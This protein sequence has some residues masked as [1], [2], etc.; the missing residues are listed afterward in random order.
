MGNYILVLMTW[1]WESIKCN[2]RK[3]SQILKGNTFVILYLN[4]LLNVWL[5][6]ALVAK[7]INAFKRWLGKVMEENSAKDC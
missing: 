4:G 3:F 6:D 2:D 1:K 7:S 5:H